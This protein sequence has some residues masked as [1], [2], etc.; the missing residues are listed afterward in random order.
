YDTAI[1]EGKRASIAEAE[2]S[3]V[4][5]MRVGN[6]PGGEEATIAL[7]LDGPLAYDDDEATLRFPLVVAPRYIPGDP[8]GGPAAGEG[9]AEDTDAVPDASRI[10]P[11]VL[12]PGFPNPVRL[13]IE[14]TIDPAGLPLLE[15]ASSLH[16]VTTDESG[17][18]TRVRVEAG[19]RVNRDFVL[20]FSY[21]DPGRV[22]S[23][24]VTAPDT[25]DS[26]RGTFQ[27]TAVPPRDL[28]AARPR[29]LV[30]LLDRSG[31]MRGWKMVAARRAAARIV[32]TLSSTDRF[33]VRCF[34]T[35]LTSP[36]GLDSDGLS[37]GT[38]RNRFRAVE[39]LAGTES[40]GG[41]NILTPLSTA[42]D[43]L[44]R[45][46][47]GRDRVIV[48]VTDGQV[49]NEDQILRE[50]SGKLA[51]MRVHVVGIDK[52]VNAGF[53]HRLSLVGRGRCELVESEDRLDEATAHIHRRIVAPVITEVSLAAD[54]FEIE[55]DT[56]APQRL[57]D[58]FTGA[59]LLI[60]GRYHHAEGTPAITISGTKQ[61]GSRWS[62][63][64]DARLDTEAAIRVSWAR[65][66]LRDLED[67][68]AAA[69]RSAPLDEL[70]KRIVDT[71]LRH[72]V[73]S[74]FTAFVAVDSRVVTE[75]GKPR[76]V[77]QPVELP[78]G[79]EVDAFG[80]P[81]EARP[82]AGAPRM[83]MAA[84]PAPGAAPQAY[85]APPPSP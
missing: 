21:G 40:R 14:A 56:L 43:L 17:G 33:A 41:T 31:S 32:D 12:L 30:V 48:L 9:Y 37:A 44:A 83:M 57:P 13:S 6:I 59:P 16:T 45:G 2:R 11:P 3:D 15:V 34:D 26:T 5:T 52:A 46:D 24:L 23:T 61:D 51:G 55:A 39:H 25:D 82:A 64:V 7:T 70:E 20:R 22:A 85:G 79:W 75:G 71:S 68:Y 81:A 1:A 4:F 54:G 74:R 66:H 67:R 8:L 47:A 42:V 58:L 36:E 29:D 80:A 72:R 50:L 18:V 28:P 63:A 65:A 76:T 69:A 77:V 27:L 38:D 49:G 60:G 19:E 84:G 53:L 62:A 10:T 35:Q 73:L 78:A